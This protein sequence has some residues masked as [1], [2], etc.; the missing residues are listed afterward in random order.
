VHAFHKAAAA[1]GGRH[2]GAPGDY[3]A[4]GPNPDGN[5][6]EAAFRD[7]TEGQPERDVRVPKGSTCTVLL[8]RIR[9]TRPEPF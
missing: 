9:H 4:F 7:S 2:N 1:N 6:I 5:S 3:A 8:N